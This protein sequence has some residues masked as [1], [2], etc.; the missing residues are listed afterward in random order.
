[1]CDAVAD[2][3][4]AYLDLSPQ[5]DGLRRALIVDAFNNRSDIG[6]WRHFERVRCT[7]TLNATATRPSINPPNWRAV[8]TVERPLQIAF[9]R[10]TV[11]PRRSARSRR[12]RC[13]SP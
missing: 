5:L 2:G 3:H 13:T 1:M 10:R 8:Q 11:A 9:E 12:A 6:H 4:G 7:R